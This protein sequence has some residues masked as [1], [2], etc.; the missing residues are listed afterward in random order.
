M[1]QYFHQDDYNFERFLRSQAEAYRMYPSEKVWSKINAATRV[2]RKRYTWAS[3][4]LLFFCIVSTAGY[5]LSFDNYQKA[6]IQLNNAIFTA[7]TNNILSVAK[8]TLGT[9]YSKKHY[10]IIAVRNLYASNS[11][12][13]SSNNLPLFSAQKNS[14]NTKAVGHWATINTQKVAAEEGYQSIATLP[15]LSVSVIDSSGKEALPKPIAVKANQLEEGS[16]SARA[17][18]QQLL[19]KEAMTKPKSNLSFVLYASPIVSYRQLSNTH[20]SSTF[21]PV[22]ANFSDDVD[23]FVQHQPAIGFELGSK[24]QLNLSNS[25]LLQAGVQF[26][27]SRYNIKAY[28]GG[29][30]KATLLVLRGGTAVADT[31][32]S[33]TSLRNFDGTTPKQL[34]NQYLQ[35]SIP[36]GVEWAVLGRKRLQLSIAA[37]LQP[38]YLLT[39]NTY[40]ISSDY[41]N[42]IQNFDLARRFNLHTNVEAFV[43]YKTGGLRWQIGPQF[44]HQSLSSFSNQYPIREYITEFGVKLGVR[45]MIR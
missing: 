12:A 21:L 25:L 42:Y 34:Q 17:L 28:N 16:A 20:R 27:Y 18:W 30:E 3:A 35:L 7:R 29:S 2:K 33:Y 41:K 11:F 13:F 26:N 38:S 1:A 32:A 22:A 10:S 40:L 9:T 43:S 4:I 19:Q 14:S 44:R 15:N 8:K 6:V 5:E 37:S 24:A 45:K 36:I 31:I 23:H 39:N